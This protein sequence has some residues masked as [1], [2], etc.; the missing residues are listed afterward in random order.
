MNVIEV[1]QSD[2]VGFL[3]D[4]ENQKLGSVAVNYDE[5]ETKERML[6]AITA[7]NIIA[8]VNVFNQIPYTQDDDAQYMVCYT[9]NTPCG[10]M[11]TEED[12]DYMDKVDWCVETGETV[13]IKTHI[14]MTPM[15]ARHAKKSGLVSEYNPES[16]VVMIRKKGVNSIFKTIEAEMKSGEKRFFRESKD[17]L[18]MRTARVYCS[19]LKKEHYI[20]IRAVSSGND[21]VIWF[22]RPTAAE[23]ALCDV[24][25]RLHKIR[26]ILNP[27]QKKEI[28]DYVTQS[29]SENEFF[30][31]SYPADFTWPEN[32]HL[33]ATAMPI[34]GKP[35]DAQA[36]IERKP[37][38]MIPEEN[39]D[40]YEDDEDEDF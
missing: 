2:I 14:K 9:E 34:I 10:A 28:L 5:L 17:I 33:G 19:M 25:D 29:F 8:G 6:R 21:V 18:P 1:K 38:G 12:V 37:G 32:G 27:Y 20:G 24:K 35:F 36:A 31:G 3:N 13:Y 15:V 22:D 11:L 39:L 23:E 7:F 30:V 4:R 40:H 26:E 16:G